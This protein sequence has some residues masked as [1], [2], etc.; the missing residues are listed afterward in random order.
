M[1]TEL[2]NDL[3]DW[4]K[5]AALILFILVIFAVAGTCDRMDEEYFERRNE[6]T[7]RLY[8]TDPGDTDTR[9]P[10]LTRAE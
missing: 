2:K 6:E 10:D 4:A 9:T 8:Y 7:T 5:G 3:K 1:R